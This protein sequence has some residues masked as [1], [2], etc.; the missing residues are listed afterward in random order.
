M[1]PVGGD[2]RVFLA[3]GDT[4]LRRGVDSLAVLV[5]GRLGGNPLS[6]HLFV[7][8]NRR[9]NTIKILF[10]DRNGFWL[11]SKR[12]E[13]D[14]FRWPRT[15]AEVSEVGIRELGWLLEG[16]DLLAVKAHDRL[17]FSAIA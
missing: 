2:T 8:C 16:L 15:V 11:L 5:Q 7:F 6:G 14:R 9:R 4:D 17:E 3:A 12:L 1:I 13:R 10:W